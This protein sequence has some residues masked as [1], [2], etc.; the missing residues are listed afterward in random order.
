MFQIINVYGPNKP[1]HTEHFYQ[2]LNKYTTNTH[3][4]TIIGRDFN[5]VI[6]LR[7]RSGGNICNTHLV[8]STALNHIIKMQKLRDIWKILNLHKNEFTYHRPQ[9]NIHSKLDKIYASNNLQTN[10][11]QI[12]PLWYSDHEVL[13][14]EFTLRVRTRGPG[15][16]KLNTSILQHGNFQKAIKTFWLDWQ[17]QTASYNTVST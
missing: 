3:N 11:S 8:G 5:M 17:K 13:L 15:Y 4:N 10:K 2:T 16:W 14:T 12:I 9:T 7:D 1:N 6:E